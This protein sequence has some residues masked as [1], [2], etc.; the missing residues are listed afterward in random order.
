[1]EGFEKGVTS[2]KM[3][4]VTF[5]Q[6]DVYDRLERQMMKVTDPD[7]CAAHLDRLVKIC[8]F[9]VE[10]RSPATENEWKLLGL[11]F[12][13]AKKSKQNRTFLDDY[14]CDISRTMCSALVKGDIDTAKYHTYVIDS[15]VN[16]VRLGC[17][18]EK[19]AELMSSL[20]LGEEN[21]FELQLFLKAS[22]ALVQFAQK[23]S[24]SLKDRGTSKLFSRSPDIRCILG[25]LEQFIR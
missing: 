21:G 14:L 19:I 4:G 22:D 7:L 20:S 8:T 12:K 9:S 24:M 11:L 3:R 17:E 15:F 23:R 6:D 5:L 10:K 25:I 13:L 1:M 16:L 18:I 2:S